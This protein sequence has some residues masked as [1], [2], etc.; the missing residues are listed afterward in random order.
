MRANIYIREGQDHSKKIVLCII[1][2]GGV[3]EEKGCISL[4]NIVFITINNEFA[5][6]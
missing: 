1:T 5:Y 2:V 3:G 4:K 6:L